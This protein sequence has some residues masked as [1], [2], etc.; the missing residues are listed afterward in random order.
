MKY[1]VGYF[2][3]KFKK[4][5]EEKW[6]RHRLFNKEKTKFCA[7]GF[8]GVTSE[9][10]SDPFGTAECNFLHTKESA[11]LN[12]LFQKYFSLSTAEIND[13]EFKIFDVTNSTPQQRIIAALTEIKELQHSK[14]KR[15]HRYK[16][17]TSKIAKLPIQEEV[18]DMLNRI[19]VVQECDARE[20]K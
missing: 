1:D 5:P 10:S 19:V 11:A 8:C 6:I 2:I 15:N 18:S 7:N 3:T 14:K 13:D 12:D 17:I 9:C 20:A 4:L 16:N